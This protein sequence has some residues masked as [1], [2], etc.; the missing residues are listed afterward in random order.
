MAL[1]KFL[2]TDPFRVRNPQRDREADHERLARLCAALDDF[3]AGIARERDGLKARYD[4]V[5]ARAAFSQQAFEDDRPDAA[6]SSK[7]DGLTDTMIRYQARLKLL[8]EQIVFV[9]ALRAQAGRFPL[10][11]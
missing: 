1:L 9:T 3:E 4:G 5:A 11:N 6:M 2:K 7:V 10:E 8:E